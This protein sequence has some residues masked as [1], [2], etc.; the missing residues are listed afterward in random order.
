MSIMSI[1]QKNGDNRKKKHPNGF[2]LDLLR[3]NRVGHCTDGDLN[4]EPK[5]ISY[6]HGCYRHCRTKELLGCKE[7][8]M[9]AMSMLF[10]L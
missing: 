9:V 5:H 1:P 10:T 7:K 6:A 2:R 8:H 3:Q 4:T